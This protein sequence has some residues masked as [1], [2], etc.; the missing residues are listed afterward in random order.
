MG[1]YATSLSYGP[2]V[3]RD[4]SAD[5]S[6]LTELQAAIEDQRSNINIVPGEGSVLGVWVFGGNVYSFRNK[7]GAATA[8][9]YKS[10]STGWSEID[11]GTALNFDSTTTNGEFVVGSVITGAA[12]ATGT[13]AAVSYSGLW[14]TCLLFTSDAADE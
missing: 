7:T 6:L 1:V 9:M 13:V 3:L 5:A 12:G 10:T 4:A 14:E 8:G 11:L 2:P